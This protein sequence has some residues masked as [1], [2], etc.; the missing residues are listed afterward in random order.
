MHVSVATL[1]ALHLHAH[2]GPAAFA[3]PALVGLSCLFTKRHYLIDLPP[4]AALGWLVCR[5][6][7]LCP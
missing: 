5:L 2:L 4:A 1:T 7:G 6:Y 3:V